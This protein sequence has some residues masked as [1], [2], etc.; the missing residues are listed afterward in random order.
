MSRERETVTDLRSQKSSPV[1]RFSQIR[2]ITVIHPGALGDSLL[3][4]PALVALKWAFS[5]ARL[6]VVGYPRY[7]EWL[8]GG[9]V[10]TVYSPDELPL[11]RLF[12]RSP[13][14]DLRLDFLAR[15]ELIVSWFGDEIFGKNLQA[16]CPGPVIFQPFRPEQL[17]EHASRFFLRT[18]QSLEIPLLGRK[19]LW[20]FTLPTPFFRAEKI[21]LPPERPRVVIHPGSG[22]PR[23]CWAVQHFAAL[24]RRLKR[25]RGIR[26]LLLVGE[27]DREIEKALRARL[28]PQE[29]DFREG[30][31]LAEVA[32]ILQHCDVYLG[33]DS[34][35]SHFA[36]LLGCA[37]LVLF[38]P[39]DPEI[40]RP[41][42]PRIN[43]LFHPQ[44]Q[45]TPE[46]VWKYLHQLLPSS[47]P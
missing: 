47:S 7:W 34:G 12:N 21:V 11:H 30:L 19:A 41:L 46:E 31:N 26:P 13:G 15:E 32:H 29:V 9:L 8:K 24:V 1:R 38:G 33:N 37:A 36:G 45:Q 20:E 5:G 17:T 22:S 27:S 16:L 43:V 23:K 18:L 3:S 44:L 2:R 42:G 39:T 28:S 35:I 25:E 6:T 4:L 10:D 14:S 40:W